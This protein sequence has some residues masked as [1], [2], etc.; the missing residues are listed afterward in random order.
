[1]QLIGLIILF[2]IIEKLRKKY[3]DLLPLKAELL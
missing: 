2:F 1:M 3:L